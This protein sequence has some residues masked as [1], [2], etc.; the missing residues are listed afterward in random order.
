M[1]PIVL[2]G[3]KVDLRDQFPNH[4]SDGQAEEFAEKLSEKSMESGFP[5]KYMPTSAKTGLNVS[6]AFD[7]LGNV[8]LD[9]VEK[10]QANR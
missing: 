1:I 7:M 6:A 8:Y 4:I 5:V 3:N 2:L 10:M 9:Y